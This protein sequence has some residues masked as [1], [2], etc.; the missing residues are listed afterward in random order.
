M[1]SVLSRPAD[2]ANGSNRN[3]AQA[4]QEQDHVPLQEHCFL[5]TVPAPPRAHVASPTTTITTHD[6]Q[7][8][9]IATTTG[10]FQPATAAASTST[11]VHDES[12]N[13][14]ATATATSLVSADATA[15]SV[16]YVGWKPSF[17]T[18]DDE[19]Y[20]WSNICSESRST[21]M[22]NDESS[23]SSTISTDVS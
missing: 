9:F 8:N 6:E 4:N 1:F 22:S 21:T 17:S 15:T 11:T 2:E 14:V 10:S 12:C 20:I 23:I 3:G 5:T 18:H 19:S 7:R 13:F 16:T